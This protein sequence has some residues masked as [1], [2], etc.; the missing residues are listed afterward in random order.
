[1]TFNTVFSLLTLSLSAAA[2]QLQS[3]AAAF[4]NAGIQGCISA[5]ENVDGEALVIHNCNTEALANQDFTL[6]FFT[7]ESAGPQLIKVFGDKCI[8]VTGGVNADGTKLQI[9]TCDSTNPN[10]QWTSVADFT[11]RWGSTNKCID[12][13]NGKITDSNQLQIYTC[14]TN[15]GNQKWLGAPN[16]DNVQ[17]APIVGGPVGG[18]SDPSH[19]IVATSNT[20]GAEV[21]IVDCLENAANLNTIFLGGNTT[22]S[23]PIAP[24]SGQY[25]IFD[26]KC[27]DV[28][29]GSTANGVKLQIWTCAAG[30]TNQLFQNKGHQIV[31]SGQNKC[32]DL[33]NGNV[34]SGNQIQLW[35]CAADLSNLNQDWSGE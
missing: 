35:D 16:P 9:W 15:N 13:T 32:V 25:K 17:V 19:C 22:W 12:L 18:P 2:V 30:N 7:K 4:T 24:L 14:G 8:D 21:A 11:L 33:T 26:D 28:P 20:D 34:T 6:N 31:W 1:M 29:N 27:L 5:A 23:Y 10:Q 3:G